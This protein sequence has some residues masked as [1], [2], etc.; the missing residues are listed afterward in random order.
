MK[1]LMIGDL[2]EMVKI[3]IV[4]LARNSDNAVGV[5][6]YLSDGD[7]LLGEYPFEFPIKDIVGRTTEQVEAYA[8]NLVHTKLISDKLERDWA[9]TQRILEPLVVK[10]DAE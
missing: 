8:I 1:K 5:F 10:E 6:K 4:G 7:E 9:E 3:R 2:I